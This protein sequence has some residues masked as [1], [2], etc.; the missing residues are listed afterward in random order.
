MQQRKLSQKRRFLR[1]VS[2]DFLPLPLLWQSQEAG[3][4]ARADWRTVGILGVCKGGGI[5]VLRL[6]DKRLRVAF[7]DTEFLASG[8]QKAD[9]YR[10]EDMFVKT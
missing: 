1:D 5:L 6:D 3:I 7:K 8:V 4:A 10:R 2:A 9:P